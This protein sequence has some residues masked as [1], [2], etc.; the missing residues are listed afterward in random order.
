[1]TKSRKNSPQKIVNP[2]DKNQEKWLNFGLKSYERSK[3]KTIFNRLKKEMICRSYETFDDIHPKQRLDII[4]ERME[5]NYPNYKLLKRGNAQ[6]ISRIYLSLSRYVESLCKEWISSMK[7][8]KINL[9]SSIS[10]LST[11]AT[12]TQSEV[13][14]KHLVIDTNPIDTNLIDTNLIHTNFIDTNRI[15][16]N[17]I[18][19]NFIDTNRIDTNRM[20]NE[21]KKSTPEFTPGKSS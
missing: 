1:M 21:S 4:I 17:L 2:N 13:L 14:K 19:T 5:D 3:V 10:H 12:L 20:K 8:E 6:Q 15:D 9:R 18:Q 16:T 7:D 11:G